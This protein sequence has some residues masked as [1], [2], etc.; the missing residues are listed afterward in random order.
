[1]VVA[2]SDPS[3]VLFFSPILQ[4]FKQCF[5]HDLFWSSPALTH[6]MISMLF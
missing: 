4:I 6:A 2:G 5:V 3:V 1:M